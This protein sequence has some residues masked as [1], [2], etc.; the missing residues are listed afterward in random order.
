[1][2]RFAVYGVPRSN[3]RSFVG[4]FSG[5]QVLYPDGPVSVLSVPEG[6]GLTP[7]VCK[8]AFPG[9]HIN[10]TKEDLERELGVTPQVRIGASKLSRPSDN[11]GASS[12]RKRII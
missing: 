3:L 12:T 10:A 2:P 11:I 1:M 6:V 4:N 5:V 9:V 8:K 7:E